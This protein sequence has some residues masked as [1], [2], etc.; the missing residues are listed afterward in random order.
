MKEESAPAVV[1]LDATNLSVVS[2]PPRDDS[3]GAVVERAGQ[4]TS[5]SAKPS[6]VLVKWR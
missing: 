3:A 2:V 6:I 1:E 5:W 4:D